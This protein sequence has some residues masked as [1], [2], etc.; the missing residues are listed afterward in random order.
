MVQ[1]A[2]RRAQGDV[3]E[4]YSVVDMVK[5]LDRQASGTDGDAAHL[6]TACHAA[7]EESRQL[8]STALDH[9]QAAYPQHQCTFEFHSPR[10]PPPPSHAV[11]GRPGLLSHAPTLRRCRVGHHN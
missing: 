7:S 10:L 3:L 5:L 4:R 1:A 2:L 11:T 9:A 6:G 8:V